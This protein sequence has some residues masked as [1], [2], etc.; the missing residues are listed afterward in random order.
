MHPVDKPHKPGQIRVVKDAAAEYQ[1]TSL[2]KHLLT[3]PDLLSS[4]VGNLMRFRTGKVGLAADIEAMYHQV[5]VPQQDADSLR[6]LWKEDI[7][8][9]GPPDVYQMLVHIF[10][11][12]DSSGC[13]NYALHRAA[14][15]HH[16]GYSSSTFESCLK[17]FYVDDLLK[18]VQSTE[19]AICL[20][21]ELIS[22]MA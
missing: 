7:T 13:A 18:A 9:E 3:G 8:K 15:D 10:G 22:I 6:F 11:A 4:L 19:D 2:N 17:A 1:G 5:R 21:E 12:K 14:R 20:A 16:R